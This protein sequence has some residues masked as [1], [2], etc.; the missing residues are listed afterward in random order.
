M[1][2]PPRSDG[3]EMWN[4]KRIKNKNKN[5]M[6]THGVLGLK[7]TSWTLVGSVR[8]LQNSEILLMA[9]SLSLAFF[10]CP[11]KIQS[12]YVF[13]HKFK[14]FPDVRRLQNFL[15]F[16]EVAWLLSFVHLCRHCHLCS[17]EIR[18][19]GQKCFSKGF[20]YCRATAS[21]CQRHHLTQFP[22]CLFQHLSPWHHNPVC[23]SCKMNIKYPLLA[24]SRAVSITTALKC[25]K[26]VFVLFFGIFDTDWCS[27]RVFLI[28]IS[29]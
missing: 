25:K 4:V 9:V 29:N 22:S 10:F 26:L 13:L 18:G 23:T 7:R 20:S 24:S 2:N 6:I 8:P 15:L 17:W 12:R 11:A 21:W 28:L 19:T 27:V 1:T 5:L 3:W 14:H 16:F